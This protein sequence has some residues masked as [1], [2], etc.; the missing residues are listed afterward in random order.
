MSTPV[1]PPS[2][3]V[4]RSHGARAWSIPVGDCNNTAIMVDGTLYVMRVEIPETFDCTKAT[5]FPSV[6]GSG[7]TDWRAVLL[8]PDA[9][10]TQLGISA[11][12][13]A[14]LNA[15]TVNQARD[16]AIPTTRL[17]GGDGQFVLVG[18]LSVGGTPPTL[19]RN[20]SGNNAGVLNYGQTATTYRAAT[21]GTGL[22][23]VPN[24]PTL[25]ANGL[26]YLVTLS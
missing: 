22:S 5:V 11:N 16:V 20:P 13:A 12:A 18:L 23:A 1:R 2:I 6:N 4:P 26:I 7:V 19:Y 21:G 24:P 17:T 25:T 9:A 3:A 15:G 8:R 10:L 14:T